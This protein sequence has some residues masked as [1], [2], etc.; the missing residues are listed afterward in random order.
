MH[1]IYAN[2]STMIIYTS[3]LILIAL[4]IHV[5]AKVSLSIATEV[6]D[7]EIESVGSFQLDLLNGRYYLTMTNGY[8][9]EFLKTQRCCAVDYIPAPN[10]TIDVIFSHSLKLVPSFQS[11][12]L[13]TGYPDKGN[14]AKWKIDI[15]KGKKY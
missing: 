11:K 13:V 8:G 9:A 3:T 2:L 4:L 14:P 7:R 12:F 15:G 6:N 5:Q 1:S 10:N